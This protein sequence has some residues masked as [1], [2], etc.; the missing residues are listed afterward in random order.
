M[1]NEQQKRYLIN[2]IEAGKEIPEDFKT[3]LFPVVQ[4]EYELNYAGK[5]RREDLLANEDGTFPV[6]LQIEQIYNPS[7]SA[8]SPEEGR[9]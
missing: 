5:M 6:P 2:L 8:L 4:K 1:L 9:G 3:L 7:H